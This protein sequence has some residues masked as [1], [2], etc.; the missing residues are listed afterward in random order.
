M[1][2]GHPPVEIAILVQDQKNRQRVESVVH[3]MGWG[4]DL[5]SADVDNADA[6]ERWELIIIA[7]EQVTAEV[8]QLVTRA[9]APDRTRV[10][11]VAEDRDPQSIAD[12][13]RA[14]SD[15]Y[16]VSPFQPE[17]LAARMQSLV[18]R[19]RDLT[20]RRHQGRLTVDPDTRTI[21][22]GQKQV[23]FSRREWD[24]LMLLLRHNDS[25]ATRDDLART[26]G[27]DDLDGRTVTTLISRIRRKLRDSSFEAI[28]VET[29]QG[30]G[31]IAR[32]R[33]ATDSISLDFRQ[34]SQQRWDS[35]R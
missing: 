24:L 27:D 8:L 33:R 29:I 30:R 11:V 34:I 19:A 18:L 7:A 5:L 23:K 22:A 13:L 6:F 21:S 12:V 31:Y 3:Q 25:P 26:Y 1:S 4:P 20:E 35:P 17:E 10:L 28:R 16:L 14:G 2:W 32:F 9:S 15:D